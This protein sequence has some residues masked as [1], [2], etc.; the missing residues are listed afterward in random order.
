[1]VA[2]HLRIS[3]LAAALTAAS[4][5]AV[6]LI[7]GGL[8]LDAHSTTGQGQE[9]A[10]A[11]GNPTRP[12]DAQAGQATTEQG[13]V[14]SDIGAIPDDAL[15]HETLR[16]QLPVAL[17]RD[18]RAAEDWLRSVWPT[19]DAEEQLIALRIWTT[20]DAPTAHR[21]AVEFELE[22]HG[23]VDTVLEA[24][25]AIEPE[26]AAL[27]AARGPTPSPATLEEMSRLWSH[28]DPAAAL[29][30]ATDYPVESLRAGAITAAVTTW[31][32]T[33]APAAARAVSAMP[34]GPT[35]L[36]LIGRVAAAWAR[37]DSAAATAWAQR[38][39]SPDEQLTAL[40]GIDLEA[41]ES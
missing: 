11:D 33:D 34:A 22:H 1:M 16:E 38:I 36:P 19:L 32:E 8:K 9:S 40:R 25:T 10:A 31:A 29:R 28:R 7:D 12:A 30:F 21:L 3:P 14:L 41:G 24:W 39:S 17:A 37:Q 15:R 27:A 13:P 26:Q 2:R 4:L 23:L 5:L 35:R 6:L 18:A 20:L